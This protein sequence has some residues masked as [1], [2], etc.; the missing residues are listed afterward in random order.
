MSRDFSSTRPEAAE[1]RPR[2]QRWA[3]RLLALAA[4]ALFAIGWIGLILPGLPTTIF[5]IFA[6]VLATRSCPTLQR[7]IYNS[8]RLGQSVKLYVEEHALTPRAKRGALIGMTCGVSV[9]AIVMSLTGTPEWIIG[10]VIAAG[11]IGG[12]YVIWGINTASS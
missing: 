3:N 10:L 11:F 6:A 2:S 1:V 5:W 8:G 4:I 12:A 7:H 9:S